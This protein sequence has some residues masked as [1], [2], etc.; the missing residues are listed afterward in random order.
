MRVSLRWLRE[1]VPFHSAP[2]E[3]AERLS[4]A[5]FEVEADE[6]LEARARGVVVGTVLTRD[7][8]PAADRL[9][10][11][12]VDVGAAD[13]LQIVCGA[14][15]V[16]QDMTVAVALVGSHLPSVDLTIKPA[17]LRGV[18][19]HGMLCS[20][21][22]LGLASESSGLVDLAAVAAGAGV[23]LPAPGEPVGP[24]LGLDDRILELAITANRPDGLSMLGIAREVAALESV[25]PT[26]PAVPPGPVSVGEA[27]ADPP[28]DGVGIA[29]THLQAVTV[30]PSPGWLQ[31]RLEAAGVRSINTVVDI[32]NLVMLETGQPLHAYD[33]QRLPVGDGRG[34]GV[35]VGR[36]GETLQT[37]D[38][39]LRAI[40]PEQLVITHGDEPV[41]LAGVIGGLGSAVNASTTEVV[42][43]AAVFPAATVRRS[44][45]GIGLRTEASARF[46]RGVAAAATLAAA[47][48]AVALLQEICGARVLERHWSGLAPATPSAVT[49]R[50][51][52]LDRLLGP[53]PSEDDAFA[54]IPDDTVVAT[55]E[56]LGCDVS[57]DEDGWHVTPPPSRAQDL[58]REV[59]LIEE[60]ARLIGYDRFGL[61]LPDPVEPGGLEPTQMVLRRLRA[62]LRSQGLQE[63][64]HLSLVPTD[65][66]RHDQVCLH[67]PLLAETSGLRQELLPALL[68]AALRNRQASRPGFWGF[69]IGH[70]FVQTPDGP[71]QELRLAGVLTG[72]R[73]S[74]RWTSNGQGRQ[75]DYW[76]A[77]GVL[78]A[79]LAE[80]SLCLQDRRL[81]DDP[82][83]HPGRA[84]GLILEGRQVGR[85]GA[86]HPAEA[87]RLDL[88]GVT[89]V[90][91]LA[92]EPLLKAATRPSRLIPTFAAYPVVP[93]SE[94]DLA[95][96][97]STDVEAAAVTQQLARA[98]GSLLEAVELLDRYT[99]TPVPDGSCSLAVRL[100][101]R[102]PEATLT[103]DQVDPVMERLRQM[104]VERF[105]ADLRS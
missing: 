26:P 78:A 62:G 83:L 16:R 99:G 38:E 68:Q 24:L 18:D 17:T 101:F 45:R 75:P 47:D 94:R 100:R 76:Q 9:S 20:L 50:R 49:L 89:H 39:Q 86:L 43:E 97:V 31:R 34:F 67:N 28:P 103:D 53:L 91:D 58:Q 61:H 98:G 85:F 69:E 96:V 13:P 12:R 56:R 63:L 4:L 87:E 102:D 37:L 60:V 104:L 21:A 33:R 35:R 23:G 51:G 30:A 95:F 66:E 3:L 5:G 70:C 65:G 84:A 72:D 10:V 93:A 80:V 8:H 2:E 15:N 44:A 22:E 32:T 46:E 41:A 57:A 54:A 27:L 92:V 52:A 7:P 42:L 48:R 36:D 6:D 88:D 1:L 82:L 71:R 64:C 81:A 11:C 79:A 105:S 25:L 55:L 29:L 19:S 90:F 73:R 77:R 14:P 74:E 40:G 59:D